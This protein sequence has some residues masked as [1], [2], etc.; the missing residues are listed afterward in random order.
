MENDIITI[1]DHIEIHPNA[2]NYSV[3]RSGLVHS[4]HTKLSDARR[5]AKELTRERYQSD[6]RSRCL[7]IALPRGH[8]LRCPKPAAQFAAATAG[9]STENS[10]RNRSLSTI[11]S[12]AGTSH[13]TRDATLP[14]S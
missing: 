7:R 10:I 9:G 1:T 5:A 3:V 11:L 8:T 6:T 12:K 13:G 14:R 2:G 4:A